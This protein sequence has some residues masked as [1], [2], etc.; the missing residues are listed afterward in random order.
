[1]IDES[2]TPNYMIYLKTNGAKEGTRTLTGVTRWNLNPVRLPIPPLSHRLLIASYRF[3]TIFAE[4]AEI[5]EKLRG[6]DPKSMITLCQASHFTVARQTS[7]SAKT[8]LW[9]GFWRT[10]KN[11]RIRISADPSVAGGPCRDRTYDQLIKSQLL[12]QLS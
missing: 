7:T 6:R 3:S 1:M 8:V 11:K 2:T 5:V 12:Y 9:S 10:N 4:I